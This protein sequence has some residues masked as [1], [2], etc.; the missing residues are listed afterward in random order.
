MNKK[1]DIYF[2]DEYNCFWGIGIVKDSITVRCVA[3]EPIM[4]G[5]PQSL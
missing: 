1:L 3:S 5:W 4:K 2:Y